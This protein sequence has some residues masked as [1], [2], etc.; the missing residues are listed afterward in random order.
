MPYAVVCKMPNGIAIGG[1]TIHGT[2]YDR[3]PGRI[4]PSHLIYGWALTEGVPDAVW[5]TWREA[6]KNSVLVLNSMIFGSKDLIE[7]RRFAYQHQG[8]AG[9]GMGAPRGTVAP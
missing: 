2:A 4:R 8:R 5:E 6:N 9:F 7:A 3:G 1:T